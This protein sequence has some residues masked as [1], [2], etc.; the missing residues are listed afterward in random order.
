MSRANAKPSPKKQDRTIDR[1]VGRPEYEKLRYNRLAWV[2]ELGKERAEEHDGERIGHRSDEALPKE[3][4][5]L[6]GRGRFHR[7]CGGPGEEQP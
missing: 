1:D 6:T 7:T 4:S 3:P 5:P 2:D